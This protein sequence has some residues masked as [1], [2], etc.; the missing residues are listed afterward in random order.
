[1]NK[2]KYT[3]IGII[4][5]FVFSLTGF[6]LFNGANALLPNFAAQ[7]QQNEHTD[8]EHEGEAEHGEEDSAVQFTTETMTEFGIM[9]DQA[10]PGTLT[11]QIERPGE[12]VLNP[13]RIS[14]IVPRVPGV[15]K[16]V[17]KS[18]GDWVIQD[19]VLVVL[20]SREL[21][22]LKSHYL[23]AFERL[24]LAQEI[25]KREEDLWKKKISAEQE[26]LEFKQKLVEARIEVHAAEQQLHT[27][28]L[29]HSYIESLSS[30]PD[31]QITRYEIRAP[32]SGRI[33]EK[34]ITLGEFVKDDS[35]VFTIAD[36]SRVWMRLTLYQKDLLSVQEGQE[37]SISFKLG[38]QN[39]KGVIS[40]IDPIMDEQTRTVSARVVVENKDGIWRPGLFVSG[41]IIVEQ[42]PV[43][44]QVPQT[45]IQT[46][47][48]KPAVFV[49]NE[50]GFQ[51][52]FVHLGRTNKTGA[53]I[54]SGLEVGQV[55][56]VEGGFALK[57][58]MERE[59]FAEGGHSH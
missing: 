3:I 31:T 4:L 56:V 8:N 7:E 14:H 28:G 1:M 27:I 52:Q 51:P 32:F 53:E 9:T 16:E 48:N 20:E 34:H 25:F 22:I 55:Y 58:E 18:V 21:A 40:Y 5:F 29:S 13:D 59:A 33:T 46:I 26:Y 24:D 38:N 23:T 45:A 39:T 47:D 2:K 11:K 15:V 12:I 36:L 6:F 19:E 37:V 49:K 42:V 44:V 57:A 41:S 35:S 43:S 10:G 54:V 17:M 30:Q 50:K